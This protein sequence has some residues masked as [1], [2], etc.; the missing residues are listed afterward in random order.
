MQT[1][2]RLQP[3]SPSHIA[4]RA[5]QWRPDAVYSI[6]VAGA[7]PEWLREQRTGFPYT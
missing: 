5:T 2:H 4:K 1:R 6:T 7:A 3:T